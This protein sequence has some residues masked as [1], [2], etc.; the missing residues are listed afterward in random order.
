MIKINRIIA[1]IITLLAQPALGA[2]NYDDNIPEIID[3]FGDI[4]A[5]Y[6]LFFD[7]SQQPEEQTDIF[8][9]DYSIAEPTIQVLDLSDDRNKN[10]ILFSE[11]MHNEE[12]QDFSH[13]FYECNPPCESNTQNNDTLQTYAST[14]TAEECNQV[15]NNNNNNNDYQNLLLNIPNV[16]PETTKEQTVIQALQNTAPSPNAKRV[17][18][19]DGI[20]QQPT[21]KQRTSSDN[22]K[23]F[24][25]NVEGCNKV[26]DRNSNLIVHTRSH[27]DEKPFICSL[28]QMGFTQKSNLT[29]HVRTHTGEKPFKCQVPYCNETFHRND[30]L[31]KHMQKIHN[32]M[33]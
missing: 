17:R 28:C 5:Y 29:V 24:R 8:Q 13:G 1:L 23:E 4:D 7:L 30:Y 2:M 11:S 21:K 3:D 31:K 6:T 22:K 26:F 27:T 25:C 14:G 15:L 18:D 16:L 10:Y 9:P 12:M 32:Q 19:S 33:K 20:Q